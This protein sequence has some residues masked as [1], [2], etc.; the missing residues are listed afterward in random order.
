MTRFRDSTQVFGQVLC[1]SVI[2]N[3]LAMPTRFSFIIKQKCQEHQTGM[4]LSF[5]ESQCHDSLFHVN[6][7]E[8]ASSI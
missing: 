4:K 7:H 6:R 5:H 8:R 3:N 2:Y 1:N